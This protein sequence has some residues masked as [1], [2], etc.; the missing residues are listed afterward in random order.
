MNFSITDVLLSFSSY[1]SAYWFCAA[2]CFRASWLPRHKLHLHPRGACTL[3]GTRIIWGALSVLTLGPSCVL[4]T[5]YFVTQDW[6]RCLHSSEGPPLLRFFFFFQISLLWEQS[7]K[8][9][10]G[11]VSWNALFKNFTFLPKTILTVILAFSDKQS[12]LFPNMK[13]KST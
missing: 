13:G 7:Y 10:L 8:L 2:L 5:L 3:S 1:L 12:L 4:L 6:E 9:L 11:K